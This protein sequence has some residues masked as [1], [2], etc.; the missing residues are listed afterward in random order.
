MSL[1]IILAD[2]HAIF[3]DG[4]RALLDDQPG[5]QVVAEAENGREAVRLARELRPD[6]V[7]MDVTMPGLNG[8]E[9]TRQITSDS[10]RIKVI[11][12]SMHADQRRVAE[13]LAAGASGYLLKNSAFDELIQAIRAVVEHGSY[14]SPPVIGPIV[15]EFLKLSS[16]EKSPDSSLTPREREV[17]QLLAEGNSSK[18]AAFLLHLNVKTVDTHRQRIMKKLK[19]NNLVELTRYAIR[20]GLTSLDL[21]TRK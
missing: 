17:L 9:A 12:L 3:R 15:R 4:L 19:L 18:E 14:L 10:S 21:P 7:V 20:E 2:D 5:M 13:M 11:S 1:R 8:V 6:L 16:G